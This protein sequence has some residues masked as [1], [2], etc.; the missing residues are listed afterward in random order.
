MK[1]RISWLDDVR[2]FAIFLVVIGHTLGFIINYKV[3]GYNWVQG[4]INR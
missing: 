2:F 1:E 3:F 4:T